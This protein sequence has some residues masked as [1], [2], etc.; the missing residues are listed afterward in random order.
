MTSEPE[1]YISKMLARKVPYQVKI[2]DG[3]F[4]IRDTEVY[5]PGKLT[6]MFVKYL[7]DNKLFID[8]VVADIGVGCFA[9]GIMAAKYGAKE[10]IG[11]DICPNHVISPKT[12]ECARENILAN[13]V[14]DKVKIIEYN[15]VKSWLGEY[16]RKIDVLA[17]GPPWDS[18]SSHE[19]QK[20]PVHHQQLSRAFY[21]IDD[22]Y[23][24]SLLTQGPRLLSPNG[25]IFITASLRV[26]DRTVSFCKKFGIK[27]NIVKSEDIH[28]DGNIHYILCLTPV[29]RSEK[30]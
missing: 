4:T 30:I 19:F 21:D 27:H 2:M 28:K 17:S 14:Q 29:D 22:H 8:K 9:L 6:G 12:I 11:V 15:R 16:E 3:S 24:I 18:I 10:V 26:L 25:K 7:V 23:I 20:I 13:G 5:P 1:K